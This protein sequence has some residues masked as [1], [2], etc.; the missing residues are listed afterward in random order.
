MRSAAAAVILAVVG[1][2]CE[3]AGSTT[4]DDQPP[5]PEHRDVRVHRLVAEYLACWDA[6]N[7][8][9]WERYERC[10]EVDVEVEVPGLQPTHDLATAI[11]NAKRFRE[12]H[13]LA[14]AEPRFVLATDDKIRSIVRLHGVAAD[15]TVGFYIAHDVGLGSH[16]R[17]RYDST[18]FDAAMANA[19]T[20][21][22]PWIDWKGLRVVVPLEPLLEDNAFLVAQLARAWGDQGR[23]HP[24]PLRPLLA[25]NLVWSEAWL[26]RPLDPA[27]LQAQLQ[28]LDTDVDPPN[29]NIHNVSYCGEYVGVEGTFHWRRFPDLPAIG[30]HGKKKD[31]ERA[32]VPFMGFFKVVNG[33]LTAVSLFWQS[34]S[35]TTQ[36]GVPPLT[37]PIR[38]L[39]RSPSDL[40]P[41]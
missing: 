12:A 40:H 10:F 15:P 1:A 6:Y 17:V 13:P 2:S 5:I 7:V 3:R 39:S 9:D 37:H 28:V 34:S 8:S 30:Y 25:D 38:P 31:R 18:Y 24:R 26:D 19:G 14:Y 16:D 29:M 4:A 20:S 27:M 35:L 21:E 36:L 22:P 32:E 33:K 41:R 11:S 23:E